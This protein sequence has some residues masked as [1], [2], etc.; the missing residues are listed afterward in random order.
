MSQR[1]RVSFCQRFEKA[2][3][4]A[5]LIFILQIDAADDVPQRTEYVG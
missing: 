2:L 1:M 5:S 3:G 4:K